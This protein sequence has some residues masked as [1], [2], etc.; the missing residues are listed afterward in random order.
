MQTSFSRLIQYADHLYGPEVGGD[1]DA[2]PSD[3]ESEETKEPTGEHGVDVAQNL[4]EEL[5]KLKKMRT[6]NKRRF[7]AMD[8]GAKHL[9]FIRC[10]DEVDPAQLVHSILQDA[11]DTKIGKS[12]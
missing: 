2:S 1:Q 3:S 11:Y 6:E 9:V 10:S 8:T 7:S 4:E 5:A 12:R